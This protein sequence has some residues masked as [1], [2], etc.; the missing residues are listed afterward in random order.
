M[1]TLTVGIIEDDKITRKLF[2]LLL[3]KA[4]FLVQDFEHGE[5]ALAWIQAT[6]PNIVLCNIMLPGMSGIEIL[7][8]IRDA[9]MINTMVIALTAFARRGE[10]E[11]YIELGFDGYISKPI[12]PQSFPDDFRALVQRTAPSI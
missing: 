6:Q 8:S 3:Q 11:K 4:G 1:Q 2:V 10:R 9:N 12:N 5:G 7:K